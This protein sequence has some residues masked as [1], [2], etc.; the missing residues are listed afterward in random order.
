[1]SAQVNGP[2]A[3]ISVAIDTAER[4]KLSKARVGGLVH[5]HGHLTHGPQRGA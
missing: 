1:M 5:I 2:T 3:T 4:G